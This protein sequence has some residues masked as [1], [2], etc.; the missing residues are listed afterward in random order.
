MCVGSF[1]CGDKMVIAAPGIISHRRVKNVLRQEM[2]KVPDL[3]PFVGVWKTLE[4]PRLTSPYIA[5]ICYMCVL[6]TIVG[7]QME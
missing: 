6:Q 3:C 1:L 4:G 7:R 2:G 5:K